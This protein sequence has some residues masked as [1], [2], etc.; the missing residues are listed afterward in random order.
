MAAMPRSAALARI[1]LVE[2]PPRRGEEEA[3]IRRYR[4]ARLS[5]E[6]PST[7]SADRAR[8]YAHL[9]RIYD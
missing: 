6:A 1:A 5:L 7:R 8:R 4:L 2:S 3:K 9:H